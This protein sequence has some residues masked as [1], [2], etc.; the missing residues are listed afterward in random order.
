[1][2]YAHLLY[3]LHKWYNIIIWKY[4]FWWENGLHRRF[5]TQTGSD[6]CT[7]PTVGACIT[8][9]LWTGGDGPAITIDLNPMVSKTVG[10]ALLEPAVIGMAIVV[11]VLTLI[12]WSMLQLAQ[13]TIP[14]WPCSWHEWKLLIQQECSGIHCM[15]P[16][17]QPMGLLL[18]KCLNPSV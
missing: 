2:V 15:H 14:Y 18:N 4:F 8:A 3:M 11:W 5:Q 13:E 1:M 12:M 9:G 6:G 7:S 16:D 10:D 17:T